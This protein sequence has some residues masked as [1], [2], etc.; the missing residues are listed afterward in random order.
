M[1]ICSIVAKNY[2]AQARVLAE[3]FRRH[4]PDGRCY[5]LVIDEVDGHVDLSDED[6]VL[7]RPA[8][9][10]VDAFERMRAIYTLM[11]L[12]TALKPWLMRFMLDH[13]D[14]GRGIA[15]FD[16]D[17][18]IHSRMTEL[19]A[20][21]SEHAVVLT[22]HV[23]R[24]MPRD[25]KRPS[26]TEI[27]QAG[28]YNLGFIGMS[29]RPDAH[30]LIEWWA[31]RLETDCFV[32]PERGYFVDQRWIDFAP[33]LI[34]DLKILRDPGYNAAYWNLPERDLELRAGAY[35]AGGRPLR[36]Y[37]FSGYS[38]ERRSEL[39][40]HQTRVDLAEHELLLQLCNHYADQLEAHGYY[41]VSTL[42]YEHDALPSGL[43]LTR[44]MR[45]LYRR[46]VE[47]GAELGPPFT[48]DGEA[49]FFA[50]L[51]EPAEHAP[52]INRFQHGVWSERP[53]LMGA[54]PGVPHGD[55]AGYLK[56]LAHDGRQQIEAP[57]ELLVP[58]QE[59][60]APAV[61]SAEPVAATPPAE[62][63]PLDEP[64]AGAPPAEPL[65]AAMRPSGVN[66]VGY[67]R[68]EVGVG[69]VARQ[70][71]GAF[72]AAGVTAAATNIPTPNSRQRHWYNASS[73]PHNPFP[74]NVLCLNADMLPAF[75]ADVGEG[76]FADRYTIGV[77]WWETDQFPEIYHAAFDLLD[78]VWVGSR[79]IAEG[80]QKV[81][82]VPVI[83][84][85]MPIVFPDATPFAVGEHGWPDA[86][87]F[88]FSWDY[89]SVFERKNPLAVVEAYTAAFEVGDGAALVL[90]SMNHEGDPVNHRR[91]LD[92]VAGRPDILII[93]T[94]L[95]ARDKDRLM[96]SC[97]CYVSLHRSE[98]LGLTIAEALFYGRPVIATGYSGNLEL[99]D[100]S[101]SDL[102]GH[103][104][105]RIGEHAAPYPAD[106]LWAEPD[107]AEAS[108][109]MRRVFESPE[110]SVP[111]AAKAARDM[112]ERHSAHAA[113][114]AMRQRLVEIAPHIPH[115]PVAAAVVPAA[116][117]EQVRPLLD[118]RGR[119]DDPSRFGRLGT[120]ARR[121]ALRV[122][123]PFTVY[124]HEVNEALGQAVAS[125]DE[126]ATALAKSVELA[127]A[128]SEFEIARSQAVLAAQVREQ[129]RKLAGL[130][131]HAPG[132]GGTS[133]NGSSNGRYSPGASPGGT[134]NG[135][136]LDGAADGRSQNGGP[137]GHHSESVIEITTGDQP[138]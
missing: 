2:L 95:D 25:G 120:V 15:Y 80:L 122:M 69:E 65:P 38:P 130:Q 111:K 56:W 40:L 101:N 81:S 61:A 116:A 16:P 5:V 87:T 48:A 23:L 85:P 31:E 106:G 24:G 59:P 35:W 137:G 51:S 91:L 44:S 54:F 63:A 96:C 50:W 128:R 60:P 108:Q 82:P 104:M 119:P 1:N 133:T 127:A 138:S 125:L 9:L 34:D 3:S 19:E 89:N 124:Q 20:A 22:P 41:A 83:H 4:H 36:F 47:L 26:E 74:V 88:L 84:V 53:D 45:T 39:S 76:F 12:S 42:P 118:L 97:D 52:E 114:A 78:E 131:R 43:R 6:F 58:A 132:S 123:R 28:V 71:I 62:H 33:G 126:Q 70:L 66:V 17:I 86:F 46:S 94:Y 21:L 57:D 55:V 11:E 98:G 10:G 13:H 18:E 93:D 100:D 92:A 72:D 32:A 113:G 14:D 27:L 121:L 8:E 79:F 77:W 136:A 134:P 112:R 115:G 68:S 117:V 73:Q 29:R 129:Q 102:V 90:K 109:L 37:H 135:K 64:V 7:V 75:A 110:A 30:T 67:L 103:R 107:V 49:A 99:M 105:V